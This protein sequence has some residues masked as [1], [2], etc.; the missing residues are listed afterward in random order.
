M[1]NPLRALDQLLKLKRRRINQYEEAAAQQAQQVQACEAQHAQAQQQEQACRDEE[2]ACSDKIET[3]TT[4]P[5]G[6]LPSDLITLRHVLETLAGNTQRAAAQTASAAQA[7]Q[8]AQ[9]TL[10]EMRRA[11]QR[12]EQQLEQLQQRRRELAQQIELAQEDTQDEESEEAAVARLLAQAREEQWEL[13][14]A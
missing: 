5:E 2:T 7:L 4:R 10:A 3:L 11:I 9:Q 13:A 14:E 12:A 6:F 1:P 8:A